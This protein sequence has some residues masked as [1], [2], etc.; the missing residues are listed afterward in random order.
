MNDEIKTA[1]INGKFTIIAALIAGI[2]TILGSIVGVYW[3]NKKYT[4]MNSG[5]YLNYENLQKDYA[6]LLAKFDAL[7]KDYNLL[8][9]QKNTYITD[10]EIVNSISE[11]D[12]A[13]I[14]EIVRTINDFREWYDNKKYD[15]FTY[16][17]IDSYEIEL[18]YK[19][20]LSEEYYK[21]KNVILAFEQYGVNCEELSINE[22]ILQLWDI[23]ILY[24]YY[25]MYNN[26]EA[27]KNKVYQFDVYKMK[28]ID[29]F[30]YNGHSMIYS[31]DT[32]EFIYK[33]LEKRINKIIRKMNR[34][35][36]P[37]VRYKWLKDPYYETT[38]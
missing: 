27:N 34:N 21:Y 30:D 23:E 5:N 4:E 26:I 1:K 25:N 11:T 8:L 18:M 20:F 9:L 29:T 13:E 12:Q 38:S 35:S 7:E 22:Y 19:L 28:E 33:D 3:E 31:N 37:V 16:F 36:L 24:T 32:Y 17:E 10:T 6:N 2:C 15:E 14:D